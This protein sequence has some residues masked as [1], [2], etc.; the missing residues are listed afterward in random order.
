MGESTK[1]AILRI[2]LDEMFDFATWYFPDRN[3]KLETLLESCGL[4]EKY[5]TEGL[6]ETDHATLRA[7]MTA[8]GVP[9]NI[10]ERTLTH[11]ELRPGVSGRA[12]VAARLLPPARE[13]GRVT[14]AGRGHGR[15]DVGAVAKRL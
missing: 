8:R 10:R 15:G 13:K 14:D 5:M 1:A 4:V 2:G 12:C 6:E 3:C 9:E 11:P 7:Y